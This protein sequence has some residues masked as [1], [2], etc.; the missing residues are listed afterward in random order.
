M[1]KLL[2]TL[3]LFALTGIITSVS[4]AQPIPDLPVGLAGS[5]AELWNNQIFVFGGA[6][7]YAGTVDN[8]LDIYKYDGATWS[9]HD[10]AADSSLWGAASVLVGDVVYLIGGFPFANTT[11]PSK[12]RKYDF[13]TGDWTYLANNISLDVLGV[14]AEYFNGKIYVFNAGT[15]DDVFEYDIVTDT[16]STK[17]SSPSTTAQGMNP[18]MYNDEIFLSGFNSTVFYKYN[19]AS[20]QWTALEPP[21]RPL[22]KCG[23]GLI[24]NKIYFA[25]GGNDAGSVPHYDDV[26]IYNI[27]TNSWSTDPFTLS[28]NKH[29]MASANISGGLQVIGGRLAVGNQVTDEVEEIVPQGTVPVELTSFTAFIADGSVILNWSTA[30]EVNNY[31]F[32]IE[33]R[34]NGEYYTIGFVEG[35]GTTTEPRQYSY[36]DK[37]SDAGIHFY[38]LKQMDFLGTF[39]YSDEIEVNVP[40]KNFSLQ[41]N[42]PNP[43][44]PGT[45]IT[46]S[47]PNKSF[48]SLKLYNIQGEEIATLVNEELLAG[49]HSFEW[50]AQNSPSGVYY[51]SLVADSKL[52]SRKMILIK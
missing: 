28:A 14:A 31:G 8:S 29:W 48:T 1:K 38:R 39:G 20:D 33:R 9:V 32:E 35:K 17:T 42:Y 16:W 52:Q 44:N 46:F 10:Q 40:L 50:N 30:T 12:M 18:V 11:T 19:P 41:Q 3:M 6:T 4:L 45:T 49:V 13:S 5:T 22:R 2:F 43:F 36:I 26:V 25:G 37:Y 34:K 24:F 23:M 27:T 7:G 47:I 51:Y 21:P 15:T